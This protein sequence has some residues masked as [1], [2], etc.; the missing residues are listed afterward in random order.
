MEKFGYEIVC[1]FIMYY[2]IYLSYMLKVPYFQTLFLQYKTT[3]SWRFFSYQLKNA[4]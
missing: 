2:K 3:P 4:F 1:L